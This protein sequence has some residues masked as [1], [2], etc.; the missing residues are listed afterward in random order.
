MLS[1]KWQSWNESIEYS[2]KSIENPIE[3]KN[4]RRLELV[5]D[6]I[7]VILYAAQLPKHYLAKGLLIGTS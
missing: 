5:R 1:W 3:L 7:V 6:E 2:G 4:Y